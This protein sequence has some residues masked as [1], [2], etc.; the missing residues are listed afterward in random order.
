[1][2]NNP[3]VQAKMGWKNKKEEYK[4]S[5]TCKKHVK[6]YHIDKP[7][8]KKCHEAHTKKFAWNMDL[9]GYHFNHRAKE[10]WRALFG[11]HNKRKGFFNYSLV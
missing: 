2:L 1:M 6:V 9:Q 7:W 10:V 5:K 8:P 4:S 11:N 3:N